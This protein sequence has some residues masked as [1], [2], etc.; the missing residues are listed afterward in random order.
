MKIIYDVRCAKCRQL[1][2]GI[3]LMKFKIGL[4]V[5]ECAFFF[6]LFSSY[7]PFSLWIR[8]TITIN[9]QFKFSI[10]FGFK[11]DYHHNLHYFGRL[12]YML[13]GLDCLYS[14]IHMH[15]MSRTRTYNIVPFEWFFSS[16]LVW[17]CVCVHGALVENS[18]SLSH[19]YSLS[20]RLFHVNGCR[21]NMSNRVMNSFLF[22]I[23]Y[24]HYI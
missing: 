22:F 3:I 12:F 23:L 1:L 4:C 7:L 11:D 10:I 14:P 6:V 20:A 13:Y 19:S 21:C 15:K 17:M 8:V 24:F 9:T 18:F 16:T 5:Y 2:I